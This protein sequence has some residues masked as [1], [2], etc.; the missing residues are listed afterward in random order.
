LTVLEVSAVDVA[1]NGG[2]RI[3][4][5]KRDPSPAAA[6]TQEVR[7]MK[8]REAIDVAKRAAETGSPVPFTKTDLFG[9]IQRTADKQFPDLPTPERRFA[10]FLETPDG[11]VLHEALKRAVPDPAPAPPT[12]SYEILAKGAAEHCRKLGVSLPDSSPYANFL[13]ANDIEGNRDDPN[14]QIEQQMP[15]TIR[16]I[17][18]SLVDQGSFSSVENAERYMRHSPKFSSLYAVQGRLAEGRAEMLSSTRLR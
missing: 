8:R 14:T 5:M 7:K 10:K 3:V 16:S 11:R 2:A 9:A 15:K 6:P 18:Q 4:L 12:S 17:A 13:K 1:A